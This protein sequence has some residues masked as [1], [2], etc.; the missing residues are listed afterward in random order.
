[1]LCAPGRPAA[2]DCRPEAVLPHTIGVFKTPSV[3]D[4]GQSEPYLHSGSLDTIES[5]LE[6]Y[7]Q[8]SKLAREG[9]LR[10][11][12]PEMSAIRIEERDI[13]PIATFLRSLNEDYH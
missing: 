11:A 1:M 3:R 6:F 12:S 10:N 8:S 4:L 7:V 2:D 13:S 5:V 9:G